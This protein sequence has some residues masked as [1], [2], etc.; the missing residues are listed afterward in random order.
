MEQYGTRVGVMAARPSR[1]AIADALGQGYEEIW[2][3]GAVADMTADVEAMVSA[4][5]GAI[6]ID[7]GIVGDS[8]ER[9]TA[10]IMACMAAKMA[11]TSSDMHGVR[12]IFR[13]ET[14]QAD[15]PFVYQIVGRGGADSVVLSSVEA[16]P[17]ATLRAAV[18]GRSDNAG[19]WAVAE[20]ELPK[21]SRKAMR[22]LRKQRGKIPAK[23]AKTGQAG[24]VADASSAASPAAAVQPARETPSADAVDEYA[25]KTTWLGRKHEE[26]SDW[27]YADEADDAEFEPKP[28]IANDARRNAPEKRNQPDAAQEKDNANGGN[29]LGEGCAQTPADDSGRDLDAEVTAILITQ[30]PIAAAAL[31]AAERTVAGDGI[32]VLDYPEGAASVRGLLDDPGT[33]RDIEEAYASVYGRK[34]KIFTGPAPAREKE[35]EDIMEKTKEEPETAAREKTEESGTVEDLEIPSAQDGSQEPEPLQ[36]APGGQD[37]SGATEEAGTGETPDTGQRE[38]SGDGHAPKSAIAETETIDDGPEPAEEPS[39]NRAGDA[40]SRITP[41][42]LMLSAIHPEGDRPKA[43]GSGAMPNARNKVAVSGLRL[44][45][46]CTH[47][48]LA[49]AL[50]F[51]AKRKRTCAVLSNR[52]ELVA[53]H[54]TIECETTWNGEGIRWCGVDIYYWS[55]QAKYA[56]EYD[57]AVLDCGILDLENDS[58]DRTRAFR[59]SRC[60]VVIGSG[61]PWDLKLITDIVNRSDRA[62]VADIGWVVAGA[63]ESTVASIQQGLRRAVGRNITVIGRPERGDLFTSAKRDVKPYEPLVGEILRKPN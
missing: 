48:T 4:G 10:A 53:L 57:V 62:T 2:S 40:F 1:S 21:L 51:A 26:R 23:Q 45:V 16:D 34:M 17:D 42:E 6:V 8:E 61:A 43:L 55:V 20:G 24:P 7:D 37:A 47:L 25:P 46:G 35:V 54:D 29:G 11:P 49:I 59:T 12:C 13:S 31:C 14:R 36:E 50:E 52:R 56:D 28:A 30:A 58:S 60:Q 38:P 27:S 19:A 5:C 9:Q 41:A 33:L 44:G 22:K 18:D 15:D 32:V 3:D 39:P 63:D